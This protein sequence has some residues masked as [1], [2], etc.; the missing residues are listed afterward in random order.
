[1]DAIYDRALRCVSYNA[2][3]WI[4]KMRAYERERRPQEEIDEIL[5]NGLR[6]TYVGTADHYNIYLAY[7]DSMV[8]GLGKEPKDED[9]NNL[10]QTLTDAVG[11]FGGIF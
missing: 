2:K 4:F 6:C 5:T 7:I 1:M 9:I 10:R 11:Y 8:R 3:I